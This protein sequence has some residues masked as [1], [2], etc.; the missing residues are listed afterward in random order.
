MENSRMEREMRDDG[1]ERGLGFSL[2]SSPAPPACQ[3]RLIH[4]HTGSICK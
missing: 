4:S 3:P 1:Q 2:C